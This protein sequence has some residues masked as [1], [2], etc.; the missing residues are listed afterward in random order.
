MAKLQ[1]AHIR[2]GVHLQRHKCQGSI[3]GL[4]QAGDIG[5]AGPVAFCSSHCKHRVY[6]W[7]HPLSAQG[8]VVH[9]T[10]SSN[11]C[12][13]ADG[14]WPWR[15]VVLRQHG[16]NSKGS[17]QFAAPEQQQRQYA[18]LL[19]HGPCKPVGYHNRLANIPHRASEQGL[20]KYIH[21]ACCSARSK[22]HCA[23]H[24]KGFPA[25]CTA[26]YS[27]CRPAP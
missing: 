13:A 3:D 16:S 4:L 18:V 9:S 10:D 8:S 27:D 1:E 2:G 7:F 5:T 24:A 15:L 19:L 20:H 23:V 25:H 22:M 21:N 26:T 14:W 12:A 17:M 6:I 11:K